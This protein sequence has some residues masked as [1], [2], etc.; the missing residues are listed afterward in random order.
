M[1]TDT[2]TST[3]S[4]GIGSLSETPAIPLR[5][6]LLGRK[7]MRLGTALA[8]VWMILLIAAAVGFPLLPLPDPTRSDYSAIAVGPGSP[9]HILGTDKIGRDML[10]RMV[11]G[12]QVSLAVGLGGIALAVL[13]GS[14]LGLIAGF[15][16]GLL[17]RSIVAFMDVLLAFPNL[18]A[19]IALSVFLGSGLKTI[20]IGVGLVAAPSVARVTRAATLNFTQREFVT[21]ARGMGAGSLRILWREIVPNVVG[22][23]IAFATVMVAVAIVAEGSLSFLGLGVPPPTSS[24]GTMMADGR[25]DFADNPHV[26]LLPAGAMFIT[27]LSLHFLAEALDRKFDFKEAA[28]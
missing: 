18:V 13:V 10:S 14:V 7:V 9:G 27:L 15:Y 22:P 3:T 24:W 20:I 26:A 21:A 17:S 2:T 4:A 16:G 6:R 1:I 12:A 19:L 23:V 5:R 11:I 25:F 28:L 8:A